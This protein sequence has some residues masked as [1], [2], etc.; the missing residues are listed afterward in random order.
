M[1]GV[2]MA[3]TAKLIIAVALGGAL[4]AVGRYFI[5]AQVAQWFSSNVP[6]STLLVNVL[7]SFILGVLYQCG[8]LFWHPSDALKAF[9]I[10]FKHLLIISGLISLIIYTLLF[11]L[12]CKFL[13][14]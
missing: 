3:E 2:G 14:P 13:G 12:T 7:G 4:G 8:L 5:S 11:I 1:L 10:V 9:L 6:W